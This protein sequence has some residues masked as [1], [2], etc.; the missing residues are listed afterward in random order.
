[1]EVNFDERLNMLNRWA[2]AIM[3]TGIGQGVDEWLKLAARLGINTDNL[4]E[5]DLMALQG[6]LFSS[7]MLP[8]VEPSDDFVA[9]VNIDGTVAP[10]IPSEDPTEEASMENHD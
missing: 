3:A 9:P 7:M 4:H 8:E 6:L 1:M 10:G 5:Y 2:G